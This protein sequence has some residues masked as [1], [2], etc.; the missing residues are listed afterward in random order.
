M[1]WDDMDWEGTCAWSLVI[2][3]LTFMDDSCTDILAPFSDRFFDDWTH[4]HQQRAP[5]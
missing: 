5:L 1:D 2:P 3:P 4:T